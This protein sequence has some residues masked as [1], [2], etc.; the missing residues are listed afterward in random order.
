MNLYPSSEFHP[1]G[2]L[3]PTYPKKR[4]KKLLALLAAV[5]L[6]ASLV[7][8]ATTTETRYHADG[9]KSVIESTAPAI[10]QDTKQFAADLIWAFVPR[11]RPV[12]PE[13]EE[14]K[15]DPGK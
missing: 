12:H 8:C 4:M 3:K 5:V 10:K 11:Q 15:V 6:P 2:T 1:V 14:P 7:G 13:K 9:S